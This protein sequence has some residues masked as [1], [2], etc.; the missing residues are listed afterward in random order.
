[1]NDPFSKSLDKH[2]FI[3]IALLEGALEEAENGAVLAA[4]T[5]HE[6]L[7]SDVAWA[8]S[9][10]LDLDSEIGEFRRVYLKKE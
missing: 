8:I 7:F 4:G 1:M 5:E 6:K 3:T 2:R 10:L 9:K